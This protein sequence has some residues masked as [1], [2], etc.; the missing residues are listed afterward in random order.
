M[1][2]RVHAPGVPRMTHAVRP[3]APATPDDAGRAGEVGR[4][5]ALVRALP[6]SGGAL[7]VTGD[8]GI[9][10]GLGNGVFKDVSIAAVQ[11]EASVDD[12]ALELGT[13]ELHLGRI[14]RAELARFM[15]EECPVQE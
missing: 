10:V 2:G 6:G 14:S 1:L 4:A 5:R 9:G 13:E 12:T 3:A 7:V 15:G 11:L 8:P